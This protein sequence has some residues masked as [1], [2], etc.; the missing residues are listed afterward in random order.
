M[1]RIVTLLGKQVK[2]DSWSSLGIADNGEGT[3]ELVQLH[4]LLRG[5]GGVLKKGKT[6]LKFSDIRLLATGTAG[7]ELKAKITYK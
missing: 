5:N 6:E 3:N 2:S 4:K 7:G 1:A